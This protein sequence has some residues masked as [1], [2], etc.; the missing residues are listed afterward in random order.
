MPAS[1][2]EQRPVSERELALELR[3]SGLEQRLEEVAARLD[4]AVSSLVKLT[5][6]VRGLGAKPQA[7]AGQEPDPAGPAELS[8]GMLEVVGLILSGEADEAQRRLQEMPAEERNTQP[9]IV[10]LAAAAM[11]MQ[12]GDYTTAAKALERA[13]SFSSDPRL[14]RVLERVSERAAAGG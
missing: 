3:L 10:A 5:Q 7:G 13:R 9:A 4:N 2:T 8:S 11:C 12:R 14:L 1:G 6:V